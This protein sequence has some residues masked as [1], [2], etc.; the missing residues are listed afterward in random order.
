[1]VAGELAGSGRGELVIG[2]GMLAIRQSREGD[3]LARLRESS[4]LSGVAR[5]GD[6]ERSGYDEVLKS[7]RQRDSSNSPS[8]ENPSASG[9]IFGAGVVVNGEVGVSLK[10]IKKKEKKQSY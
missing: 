6:E 1:V 3:G 10:S 8:L 7:T 9:K 4:R 2:R 5:L